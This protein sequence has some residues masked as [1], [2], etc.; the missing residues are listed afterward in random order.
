MTTD[1]RRTFLELNDSDGRKL[2]IPIEFVA[3]QKVGVKTDLLAKALGRRK[4]G[5]RILVVDATA[6]LCRDSMHLLA[7]GC[8]VIAIERNAKLFKAFSELKAPENF[9]LVHGDAVEWL[10]NIDDVTD[11]LPSSHRMPDIVFLDPM[12]PEK[13]KSAAVSKETRALQ[14]LEKPPTEAEESALLTAARAAA[15]DRVIVKRPRLAPYLAGQKPSHE[16]E[17]KAVRYDVY[18]VK[19]NR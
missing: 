13:A 10:R 12:F 14:L 18:V 9:Q 11:G 7:L 1:D 19:K 3:R 15:L 17:G 6:G 2:K 5:R 8:E 16:Y 4:S